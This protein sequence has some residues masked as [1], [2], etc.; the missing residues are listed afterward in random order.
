MSQSVSAPALEDRQQIRQLACG[1]RNGFQ[2][3]LCIVVQAL[4][5][6]STIGCAASLESLPRLARLLLIVA[7]SFDLCQPLPELQIKIAPDLQPGVSL[8]PDADE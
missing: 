5:E 1:V 3:K 2:W 6:S 7:A 8:F 4:Q